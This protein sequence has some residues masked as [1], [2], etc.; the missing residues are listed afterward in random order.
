VMTFTSK[1]ER[2]HE[3]VRIYRLHIGRCGEHEDLTAAAAR[4]CLIPCRGIEA[5]SIDHV[6]NEFWDEKWETWEPTNR[7]YK[8][9]LAYQD[10]SGGIG[11]TVSI[12]SDGV[13]FQETD[14]YVPEFSTYSFYARDPNN[15]PI[16]GA[17]VMTYK[18][19]NIDGKDYIFPD[20]YGITDNDGKYTFTLGHGNTYYIRLETSL[21]NFPAADNTVAMFADNSAGGRHYDIAVPPANQAL[22]NS[23]TT[24][25][26]N[27]ISAPADNI[28]DFVLKVTFSAEKQVINWGVLWNDQGN[29]VAYNQQDNSK[30]NFFS[31]DEANYNK[32]LINGNFNAFLPL[33]GISG[34]D[35]EFHIP[36]SNDWYS[37]LN[38]SNCLSNSQLISATF[39]LYG[40]AL[41][42]VNESEVSQLLNNQVF[43]NPF[44]KV[45][46][47]KFS[48]ENPSIVSLKIYNI[49]GEL[50]KTLIDGLLQSG[51]HSIQW[52]GENDLSEM[53]NS[54]IYYYQ[55]ISGEQHAT[56]KIVLIR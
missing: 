29:C 41:N 53:L 26:F 51:E 32:C 49:H 50:V 22:S 2:P 28:D 15:E 17:R 34:G 30:V 42:K 33:I 45:T 20:N 12:R 11:S 36:K 21:G 43:P 54:G 56:D 10:W 3:P 27:E 14:R 31:T 39:V 37:F 8:M 7:W 25:K 46:N 38:N 35:V 19:R 5:M 47:I 9:P 23:K 16:D 24:L 1:T 40:N 44:N 6:W 13:C 48:L 4:A 18:K 55:L 52:L